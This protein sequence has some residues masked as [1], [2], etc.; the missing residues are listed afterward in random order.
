[1]NDKKHISRRSFL[2]YVGSGTVA[3]LAAS[4]GLGALTG[5]AKSQESAKALFSYE[6]DPLTSAPGLI[7]P[8]SQDELLLPSGFK[9]DVLAAFG[10]SINAKGDTFG[11]NNS[12]TG[13][14]PADG[15]SSLNGLLWVHHESADAYW[16]LGAKTNGSYSSSQI[17]KLLY[18]QGASVLG[19]YRD[20][21]GAWKMD[22]SAP[23]ARRISGLDA[24]E[25]AG[26]ARGA[27]AVYGASRVQGTLG[28]G[29][30]G[31]TLW[32]TQLSSEN[33]AA[34]AAR[35]AGLPQ[36][37]YGWVTEEDPTDAGFKLRK[38][39]A[40]GRFQHGSAAM[41]L[42]KDGRVVV[43][44]GDSADYACIYKYISK[45]TYD[46]FRGKANSDLLTDG[47]LYAADMV[48]GRW[49]ALRI[50]A[51]R[52]A[53]NDL[54]T[55]LPPALGYTREELLELFKEEAD[56]YVYASEA[57]LLLGATPTDRPETVQP[58]PQE[59]TLFIAHMNNALHGNLHGHISHLVEQDGDHGAEAFAFETL[60]SGGRQG[61]FSSPG[62]LI[63][64]HFGNLWAGTEIAQSQLNQGAY[65]EF[66]NNG[67]FAVLSPAS[68]KR[69]VLQFASAPT[70]AVLAGPC[71]TPDERTMFLAVQYPGAGPDE[72]SLPAS[73][74][75]S[76]GGGY[77][78]PAV[79]AISGFTY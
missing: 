47:T 14:Y 15:S 34:L 35:D 78:R 37:H 29:S 63:T 52:D 40:L 56:V 68:A 13:Y 65:A 21:F 33:N 28:S 18:N 48:K 20:A 8:S 23:S 30:G 5:Q 42:S 12:Y 27:K 59:G 32:G 60:I 38:H 19:V 75:L 4:S 44:M 46:P 22:A 39:T 10:D 36:T 17:E 45:Q 55:P 51:V 25:L 50:E 11:F 3:L 64:D 31:R 70:G 57:A 66:K 2:A 72:A 77:P 53:L 9:Y 69:K 61:E 73:T 62:S 67:L 6:T 26:P 16:V 7:P 71:F 54:Q 41:T 24:F 74:W 79:V 76:R 49:V 1:M 43:Y 58:S